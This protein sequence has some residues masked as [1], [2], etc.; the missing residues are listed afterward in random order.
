MTLK[1]KIRAGILAIAF[2]AVA[3]LSLNL[4]TVS[5]SFAQDKACCRCRD[6]C[7][8]SRR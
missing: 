5:S 1:K 4:G 7:R 2:A 6:A 8:G 3:G